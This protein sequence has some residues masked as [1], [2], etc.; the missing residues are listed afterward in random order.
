MFSQNF[1]SNYSKIQNPTVEMVIFT[2]VLAFLLSGMIA[3]TYDKTTLTTF[4]KTNFTQA[5]ILSAIIATMVLQ[6]IG[7]N[8][9]SGLGMLGALHVIQFR[10]ALRN[11]RDMIFMFA[12]LGTGISCGLYGF[13]IASLG[14]ILFCILAFVLRFTPYHFGNHGEWFLYIRINQNR[15]DENNLIGIIKEY[16]KAYSLEIL[17]SE[18][19]LEKTIFEYKFSIV[20][21]DDSMQHELISELE[22][23]DVRT[24]KLS[25]KEDE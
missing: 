4:R 15:P 7:D 20:L 1:F 25:R 22:K 10:N 6:A 2:F 18:R 3:I 12:A 17:E 9:A 23:L 21:K 8:V 16:C 13:Y 14:T 19:N 24:V 11:P 5:L